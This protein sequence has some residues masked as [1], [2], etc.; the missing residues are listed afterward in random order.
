MLTVAESYTHTY[1]DINSRYKDAASAWGHFA[2]FQ[3]FCPVV[4]MSNTV[5][6]LELEELVLAVVKCSNICSVVERT[7]TILQVILYT[8]N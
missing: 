7:T 5:N 3:Y 6:T 2:L 4:H 1:I 8:L